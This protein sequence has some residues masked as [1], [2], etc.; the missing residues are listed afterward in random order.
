MRNQDSITII[1]AHSYSTFSNPSKFYLDGNYL[2]ITQILLISHIPLLSL[3]KYFIEYNINT[4]GWGMA[5][6]RY[7]YSK[8]TV[9]EFM[10]GR[11]FCSAWNPFDF[12][13]LAWIVGKPL[14]ISIYYLLSSS[15]QSF[16]VWCFNKI[17]VTRHTS[18]AAWWILLWE[19]MH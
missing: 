8:I 11:L 6:N 2:C 18:A 15:N 4:I 7:E 13:I 10:P 1:E 12:S 19:Q 14:S 17:L 16:S 9:I 5:S 3:M